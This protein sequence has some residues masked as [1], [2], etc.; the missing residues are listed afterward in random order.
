MQVQ[1]TIIIPEKQSYMFCKWIDKNKDIIKT[2]FYPYLMN[3]VII[4]KEWQSNIE[5]V[6][7]QTV[8]IA[9]NIQDNITNSYSI[10]LVINS[11]I[12]NELDKE[13]I[14]TSNFII[15]QKCNIS[16]QTR[17]KND[18]DSTLAKAF[19][20][21]FL[22]VNAYLFNYKQDIS[23]IEKK[24]VKNHTQFIKNKYVCKKVQY[25]NKT[26]TIN[27]KI[28]Q[29]K[30]P[31]TRQWH[32]DCWSVRGHIRHYKNGKTTYIKPYTKGNKNK[33]NNKIIYFK[34]ER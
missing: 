7:I 31:K 34:K 29:N 28:Y 26:Y 33:T 22:Y 25:L 19:I 17:Q 21:M 10:E 8:E 23:I 20:D 2:Q 15:D 1:N 32:I 30:L 27:G 4:L 24:T 3:G 14:C 12:K 9:F 6:P 11:Y 16:Y 5:Y 18:I 13:Q